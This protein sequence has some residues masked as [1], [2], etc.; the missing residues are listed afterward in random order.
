[1]GSHEQGTQLYMCDI[2]LL[3]YGFYTVPAVGKLV[4]K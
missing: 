2:Y 4:Q 1:M 3:Q